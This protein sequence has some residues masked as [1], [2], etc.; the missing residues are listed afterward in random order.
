MNLKKIFVI[1][2]LFYILLAQKGHCQWI[3]VFYYRTSIDYPVRAT[4]LGLAFDPKWKNKLWFDF[5][6]GEFHV[7]RLFL[8]DNLREWFHLNEAQ[9][10]GSQILSLEN[11]KLDWKDQVGTCLYQMIEIPIEGL[12][13]CSGTKKR[14]CMYHLSSQE[15]SFWIKTK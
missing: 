11:F 13:N 9:T 5:K 6:S 3:V 2:A 15:K 12:E 8:N 7:N 10:Y 1:L 4:E 14:N